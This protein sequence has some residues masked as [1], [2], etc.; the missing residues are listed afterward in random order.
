[1]TATLVGASMLVVGPESAMDAV[2]KVCPGQPVAR[3]RS[4]LLQL[5]GEYG[6]GVCSVCHVRFGL[7]GWGTAGF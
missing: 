5:G 1:M 3:V 2:R 7:T 6:V 4:I